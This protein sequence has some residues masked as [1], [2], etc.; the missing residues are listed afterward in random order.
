[1]GKRKFIIEVI[2]N[3]KVYG[4]IKYIYKNNIGT[5][6]EITF[7]K[8]KAKFWKYKKNCEKYLLN[9]KDNLDPTKKSLKK[10]TYNIIEVTDDKILRKIKLEKLNKK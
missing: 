4:Y 5:F 7:K 2:K 10:Y 8:E 3:D 1:M 9:I 6:Y